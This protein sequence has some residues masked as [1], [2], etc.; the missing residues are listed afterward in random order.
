MHRIFIS[1]LLFLLSFPTIKV[2]A[3][4]FWLLCEKHHR[5]S[6]GRVLLL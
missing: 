4:S 2:S 3:G 5:L 1:R 6:Q